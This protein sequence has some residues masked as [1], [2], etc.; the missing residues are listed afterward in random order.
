MTSVGKTNMGAVVIAQAVCLAAVGAEVRN[1]FIH[2]PAAKQVPIRRMR[3]SSVPIR[4]GGHDHV[5]NEKEIDTHQECDEPPP[6]G[7]GLVLIQNMDNSGISFVEDL[8]ELPSPRS[9]SVSTACS[10]T[11]RQQ[12][13]ADAERAAACARS[14]EEL[15]V[16]VKRDCSFLRIRAHAVQSETTA[17]LGRRSAAATLRFFI[18]GLP[19]A[20]RAKWLQPLLWSVASVLS[21]AGTEATVKGGE[22]IAS[23]AGNV[24]V[25]IDF[26]AARW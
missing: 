15:A 2:F 20:K 22:L 9:D 18:H 14:A 17:K 6:D 25:R 10:A 1:T 16:L 21:R 19:W 7:D 12:R 5:Y 11:E 8:K 24:A 4:R 26:T 23:P 3:A 13:L